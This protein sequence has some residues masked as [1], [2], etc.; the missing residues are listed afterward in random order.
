VHSV[1]EFGFTTFRQAILEML[2]DVRKR[3]EEA[4]RQ[5]R[6]PLETIRS[7]RQ[8]GLFRAFAPRVYGGDERTLS[9]VLEAMTDLATG[10]PSSAWVGALL[11]IHNIA[12][13]WLDKKGQEEIFGEGPDVVMSS[14]VAPTGSL[15]RAAGGFRLAGRWGFSSGVDH[16]SWIMLGG[17]LNEGSAPP[18]YFLCFVRAPQARVIDD[19]QVS[20]LRATGSKSVELSDVFV[21]AHRT[22][23][24]RT[25]GEG[26]AAGLA[27]HA[28]PFYRLPWDSL[29]V[30]AL[31]PAALGA[32][33][34]M[35]EA[36][37]DYTGSRVNRFSGR[38]F[39]TNAG[40][41]MRIAQAAGQID[42]ARLV[43]R[44]DLAA[45]DRA[46]SEG[47]ALLP[48][49]AERICF[50]VPFIV[51]MCSEAVLRLFRGSGGRAVHESNPLQRHFRDIHA[52]TQHAAMDTDRAGET[53]GRALIQNPALCVGARE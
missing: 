42:A 30:S 34:A 40:S 33:V 20:G 41:A 53:Y 22:L 2:P 28:N 43:F 18:E 49:T 27:C 4:E 46:A 7:L 51:D 36:F 6:I 16:A 31:A 15:V 19:W 50:D 48:G 11:A 25:V 10:C 12:I 45:L 37:R 52:M 35:L 23:L 8:L 39:R 21:P 3:A 29:F 44:R 17:N 13:C 26:T 38:G 9:E 47:S 32:A 14:S 1:G 5:R 24:L